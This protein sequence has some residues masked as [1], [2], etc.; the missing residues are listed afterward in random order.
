MKS[1]RL[2]F[3]AKT[4][5]ASSRACLSALDADDTLFSLE[6]K[7]TEKNTSFS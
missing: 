4:T 1:D 2:P 5:M 6:P 3:S 7:T